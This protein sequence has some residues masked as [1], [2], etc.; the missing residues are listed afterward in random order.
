SD[1]VSVERLPDVLQQ[2]DGEP[3]A[4]VLLEFRQPAQDAVGV[5]WCGQMLLNRWI[6][7]GHAERAKQMNDPT[8]GRFGE[9]AGQVRVSAVER[10]PNPDRLAVAEPVIGDL[11]ELVRGPVPEV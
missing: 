10:D 7:H 3:A 5:V 11:L 9:E 6:V 4:E 2:H 1:L 8:P